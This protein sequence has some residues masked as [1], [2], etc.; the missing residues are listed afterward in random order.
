[1][2]TTA[3]N[4]NIALDY[5]QD[6]KLTIVFIIGKRVIQFL[7]QLIVWCV[8]LQEKRE[9]TQ[10]LT[11]TIK[12]EHYQRPA[13]SGQMFCLTKDSPFTITLDGLTI[14]LGVQRSWAVRNML[15]P[16][17]NMNQSTFHS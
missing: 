3:Q 4:P 7:Q 6:S 16:V 9:N 1:M 10:F 5:T 2:L 15:V 12:L 17:F 13:S 8:N 14:P 11:V